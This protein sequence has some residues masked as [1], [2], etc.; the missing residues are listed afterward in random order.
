MQLMNEFHANGMLAR[1]V[2]SS[3]NTLIPKKDNP[4]GLGDYRPIILV[5]SVYKIVAKVLSRRLRKVLPKFISEVQTS[6]LSGRCILDGVLI[7]NKVV[8]W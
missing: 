2:N 5:S 8:D 4:M 1:G 3:F 6:F 7:A